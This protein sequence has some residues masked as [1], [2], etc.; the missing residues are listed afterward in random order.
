M[1]NEE[2]AAAPPQRTKI[3]ATLGPASA[4]EKMIRK[5]IRAGVSVFRLNFAHGKHEWL[6]QVVGVIREAA[7]E[8]EA[9]IA[10]LGDLSGPK[11]RLNEIEGGEVC[12]IQG[13]TWEFVREAVPG[14]PNKL[15]CT[16][17]QLIDDLEVGD[18]VVLADGSVINRVVEKHPDR[19]VC[20]VE[21][22]GCVRS[23]QGVNLPGATL[24]TP[25]LTE[26]DR[27]DLE[28]ACRIGLDYVGLSFVR[29]AED[30]VDLREAITALNPAHPPQIVAKI[31]KVEA[32]SDLE[33]ILAETDGVM[34]AR[35]D[36]GVEADLAK[37]PIL[38]KRIIKMCNKR[39]IPVIT[40]TQMLESMID[41]DF[42]TRA[43]ATDVCNA[44][45]DGTD[46]V[47]L[48]GETAIG[49]HPDR[50]VSTMARIAR[51]AEKA[52]SNAVGVNEPTDPT[53]NRTLEATEAVT[54]GAVYAAE[55]IRADMVIVT[56]H[57]GRT[58]LAV[59][60]YR[61][62]FPILA[63][64]DNAAIAR[65]MALYWGVIPAVSEAVNER[66]SELMRIVIDWAKQ[67]GIVKSG[68]H[69]VMVGST[70]WG[71]EGHDLMLI[72]NVT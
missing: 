6:E 11:I 42:P 71:T 46:A 72:H 39:R 47:M 21:Q 51:E 26:K 58:A 66:Q 28:F 45:L 65:R 63:V 67:H 18:L 32:V 33:R 25:S 57:G 34:V 55:R 29:Q 50:V 14:N 70:D 56:T 54:V 19:I 43:E 30:I 68:D 64:T 48:S 2:T 36:L 22:A 10:L 53:R 16:Y 27:V 61:A 15:T 17:G 35:G 24:S 62:S 3:V 12:W 38:Q 52:M 41:A 7:T 49:R 13:G 60:K 5:L 40:A 44:V 20:K 1:S 8:L 4:S 9:S 31:E 37:V 59:S 23:R 69:A